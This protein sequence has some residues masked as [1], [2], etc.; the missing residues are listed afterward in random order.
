MFIW[1]GLRGLDEDPGLS[2]KV[3]LI[4]FVNWPVHLFMAVSGSHM[5]SNSLKCLVTGTGSVGKWL[6]CK[7]WTS[8]K[9]ARA[10][11]TAGI[12]KM[13][14]FQG[15]LH[16]FLACPQNNPHNLKSEKPDSG[17]NSRSGEGNTAFLP[18]SR[19]SVSVPPPALEADS[20]IM[21]GFLGGMNTWDAQEKVIN[22]RTEKAGVAFHP[23]FNSNLLSGTT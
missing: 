10:S 9:L 6:L 23:E 12:K 14:A 19:F 22:F 2:Q 4:H 18:W 15:K 1:R 20:Q 16:P 11:T 5:N 13:R 7:L 21:Q 17:L 3:H 8:V